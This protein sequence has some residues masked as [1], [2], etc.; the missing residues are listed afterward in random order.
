[1][2]VGKGYHQN[3]IPKKFCGIDSKRFFIIVWKKAFRSRNSACLRIAHSEVQKGIPNF[4]FIILVF[5]S[6]TFN[7]WERVSKSFFFHLIVRNK[8]PSFFL[9]CKT[10]WTGFRAFSEWFRTKLRSSVCFSL[11]QNASE[12]NNG[13]YTFRGIVWNGIMKLWLRIP[14]VFRSAKQTKSWR[15]E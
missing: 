8:I 13:I 1:M 14:I 3:S 12:W 7:A 5:F 10:G 4:F 11:L 9:F 6:I 15:N 2:K